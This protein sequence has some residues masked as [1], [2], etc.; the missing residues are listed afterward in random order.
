MMRILKRMR[1]RNSR[2]IRIQ[3]GVWRKVV[4]QLKIDQ[5]HRRIQQVGRPVDAFG[6][7]IGEMEKH[8][9]T[10]QPIVAAQRA[11]WVKRRAA[12]RGRSVSA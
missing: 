6:A 1:W 12:R 9:A 2:P 7:G 3:G 8:V 10:L 11:R 4:R 5:A